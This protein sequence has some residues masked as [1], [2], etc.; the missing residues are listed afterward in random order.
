MRI[1]R[2]VSGSDLIKALRPLGYDISRQTGSHIRL[3]TTENGEH[4]IT[5]PDHDPIR[6]G[7]LASILDAVADHISISRTELILRIRL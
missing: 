4:H 5:V 2:D 6:V 1:P 3:T 7:T